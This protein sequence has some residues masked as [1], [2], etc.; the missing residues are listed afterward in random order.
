MTLST[1]SSASG[2][3]LL[4]ELMALDAPAVGSAPEVNV[5]GA[6]NLDKG[7]GC[8]PGSARSSVGTQLRSTAT[9]TNRQGCTSGKGVPCTTT[10]VAA[11]SS[12]CLCTMTG[13]PPPERV[14]P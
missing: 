6:S 7:C 5:V 4:I 2:A 9:S 1:S 11:A 8:S 14:R 13:K 10:G 3:A 12:S